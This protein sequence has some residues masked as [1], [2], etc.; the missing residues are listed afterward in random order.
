MTPHPTDPKDELRRELSDLIRSNAADLIADRTAEF[1]IAL[2]VLLNGQTPLYEAVD[3]RNLDAAMSLFSAGSDICETQSPLFSTPWTLA[4]KRRDWRS[5]MG[6]IERCKVE[7]CT[8]CAEDVQ[9]YI[10]DPGA[11]AA[12]NSAR[13]RLGLH[14]ESNL[15][16]SG[17]LVEHT[18]PILPSK[19]VNKPK[20]QRR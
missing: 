5:V 17:K 9:S 12:Y 15:T 4:L 14:A 13:K 11:L 6:L 16:M 1:S 3:T 8:Q 20:G 2:N 18:A 19:P 10:N 7:Q